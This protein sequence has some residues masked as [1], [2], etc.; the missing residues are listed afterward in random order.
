MEVII[1]KIEGVEEKIEEVKE[2]ISDLKRKMAAARKHLNRFMKDYNI[3]GPEEIEFNQVF[4][5][6]DWEKFAVNV[7]EGIGFKFDSREDECITHYMEYIK[8]IFKVVSNRWVQSA[9]QLISAHMKSTY[10]TLHVLTN[11]DDSWN[12]SWIDSCSEYGTTPCIAALS[13]IDWWIK[14]IMHD[15]EIVEMDSESLTV[16]NYPIISNDIETKSC[17]HLKI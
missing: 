10:V 2:E 14:K 12:F 5:N 15:R 4:K 7:N 17:H 13:F 1:K 9:L 6:I 16:F 8:K 3:E 11:L